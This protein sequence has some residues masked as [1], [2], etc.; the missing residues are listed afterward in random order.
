M[1]K[2]FKMF[3]NM[4]KK[5]AV[6]Y[7]NSK[8]EKFIAEANK[9]IN[10]PLLDEKDEKEILEGIWAFVEDLVAEKTDKK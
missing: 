10:I 1:D 7:I 6:K 4:I 8:K 9:K 2:F 5:Y 3:E